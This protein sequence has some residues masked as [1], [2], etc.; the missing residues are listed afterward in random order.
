MKSQTIAKR[1]AKALLILGLEDGNYNQYCRELSDLNAVFTALATEMKALVSPIYPARVRRD[2]L[3]AIL[4]KAGLSPMV[5]NFIRLLFEKGRLVEFSTISEVYSDLVD[6]QNGI[7]RGTLV[8]AVPLGEAELNEIKTA[9]GKFAGSKVELKVIE[10]PAIIGGVVAR[11][12]D[13]TIDGSVRTQIN[14]LSQSLA[15]ITH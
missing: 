3:E 11:L 14:K 10:D 7:K 9:L 6:A 15:A 4:G 12:G 5:A 8:S 13:L 2:I 1:Y